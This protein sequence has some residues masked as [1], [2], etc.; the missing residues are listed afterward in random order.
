MRTTSF[1]GKPYTAAKPTPRFGNVMTD[2]NRYLGQ[3]YSAAQ[4]GSSR[5]DAHML[6]ALRTLNDESVTNAL[7]EKMNSASHPAERGLA[8]A[9]LLAP[10]NFETSTRAV[11]TLR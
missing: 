5:N 2:R 11:R 9:A 10:E 4:Q 6:S 7:V 3:C 8:A 1:F